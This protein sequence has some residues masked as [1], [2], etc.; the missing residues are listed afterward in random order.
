[1][2]WIRVISVWKWKPTS[3]SCVVY[4]PGDYNVPRRAAELAVTAGKAVMIERKGNRDGKA[5]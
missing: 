3:A 2:A 1:M 5:A 4:Q